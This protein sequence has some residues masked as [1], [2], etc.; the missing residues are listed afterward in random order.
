[1]LDASLTILESVTG[2]HP[3]VDV[4]R[5]QG[6]RAQYQEIWREAMRRRT[7]NRN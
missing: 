1:M 6:L 2:L 4:A 7:E 5:V 3:N